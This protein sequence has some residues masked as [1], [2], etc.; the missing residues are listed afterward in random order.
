MIKV[1]FILEQVQEGLDREYRHSSTLTL[2][3]PLGEWLT[4]LFGGFSS[5][6]VPIVQEGWGAPGL[7]RA[8][9]LDHTGI[10]F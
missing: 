2:T 1:K 6:P 5:K 4:L 10:R 7:V 3:S 9:K 8:E